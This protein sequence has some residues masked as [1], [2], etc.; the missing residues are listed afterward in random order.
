M[1]IGENNPGY[2]TEYLEKVQSKAEP[3]KKMEKQINGN[4]IPVP[5]D[6]Y[7]SS[8][9]S[10]NKPSGLYRMGQDDNGN[11]KV[12]YDDPKKAEKK[13]ATGKAEECITNTDEVDRKIEKLKEKKRQIE[14]QIQAETD[15]NKVKELKKKLAQVEAELSQKNNDTYRRQNAVVIGVNK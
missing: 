5:K 3:V 9:K 4:L 11:P 1:K 15:E 7:I 12:L 8:E 6:E 13:S 10:G 2:S 14:Q